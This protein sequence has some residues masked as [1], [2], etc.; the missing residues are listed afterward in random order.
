MPIKVMCLCGKRLVAQDAQAGKRT[1]CP[2]CGQ[3]L[4]IPAANGF[5]AL[6]ATGPA[7]GANQGFPQPM[8][9]GYPAGMPQ[10]PQAGGYDPLTGFNQAA[11]GYGQMPPGGAQFGGQPMGQMPYGGMQPGGF[12]PPGAGFAQP[13]RRK[14]GGLS[15]GM[16]L[17]IV[18]LAIG[19]PCLGVGGCVAFGVYRGVTA[20]REAAQQAQAS[21]PTAM[22]SGTS[23]TPTTDFLNQ[24][25]SAEE[26]AKHDALLDKFLADLEEYGNLMASITDADSLQRNAARM[27]ELANEINARRI[28]VQ[29]LP[30]SLS[31]AENQR[32]D[33]KYADRLK[34]ANERA[35]REDARALQLSLT[36]PF[37]ALSN[38]FEPPA[39]EPPAT[40]PTIPTPPGGAIPGPPTKPG[41]GR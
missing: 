12:M 1:K 6:P 34:A 19:V 20:V 35:Q 2:A 41:G 18:G 13:P 10:Q 32:L 24:P 11:M 7:P 17:G 15:T 30:I 31:A 4:E 3:V 40:P 38:G 23:F 33:Q 26:Q 25:V 28:E 16:I 36:L 27:Q 37:E 14:S 22:P 21:F 5:Q 29:F 8:N 39:F 9:P